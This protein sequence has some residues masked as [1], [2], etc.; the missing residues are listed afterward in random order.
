MRA[1]SVTLRTA[2]A[3]GRPQLTE[4]A[5]TRRIPA[6]E[7]KARILATAAHFFAEY[8]LTAQTRQLA[9]ACGV[10]QRLLYRFFPTKEELVREVYRS[11]ILGH[12]KGAWF[13]LLQDRTRPVEDRLTAFYD[14]YVE[15]VLTRTWLRL[16]LYASLADEQMA[17]DYI[18]AIVRQLVETIVLEV[19]A[20]QGLSPPASEH[21]RHELGWALHGAISHY[22]IRRHLYGASEHVAQAEIVRMYVRLFVSGFAGMLS[23]CAPATAD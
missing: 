9:E 8:G 18:A 22:A 1:K 21:V 4:R 14:E 16:F 17:P 15:T 11:E 6:A 7:R 20:E 2:K 3:A 12:F 10:S 5:P 13:A 19:A 23:A